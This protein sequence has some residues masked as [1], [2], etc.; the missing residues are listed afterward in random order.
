VEETSVHIVDNEIVREN[1]STPE[2]PEP[3]NLFNMSAAYVGDFSVFGFTAPVDGRRYRMEVSPTTGSLTYVS[4]LAD[5]RHYAFIKPVAFAARAMHYGRYLG[6]SENDRLNQLF[7]GYST[8]VRGYSVNSFDTEDCQED[9]A[10]P[11]FNRLVGSR[12][13]VVNFE[14][15][16]PILGTEDYGLVNFRYLPTDI[17]LFLDG[18]AAWGKG[19]WPELSIE[20]HS[21]ER[22]PVFSAGVALRVNIL[23]AIVGQLYYAYPF[24]R[25]DK[26]AHFGFAFAPGW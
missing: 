21:N 26:G 25:P 19:D 1:E 6:D 2:G 5:Y 9:G 14:T 10:C 4:L 12:V 20:T 13:F 7:L 17:A 8:W 3:L 24:Q 15:R 11:E 18:G 16:L 23:G 22:I